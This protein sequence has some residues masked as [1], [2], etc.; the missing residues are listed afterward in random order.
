MSDVGDN[1]SG[2]GRYVLR[3]ARVDGLRRRM[4]AFIETHE[5]ETDLQDL[6]TAPDVDTG[7]PMSEIVDEGR[8]ERP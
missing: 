6:R 1:V 7:K 3:T 4:T 8:N 5:G 2:L